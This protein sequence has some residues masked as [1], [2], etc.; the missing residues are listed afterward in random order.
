MGT[1]YYRVPSSEEVIRKQQKL[2]LRLQELD[3][4]NP[5]N[6]ADEFKVLQPNDEWPKISPWDEFVEDMSVHLG[7]RSSGWKFCWN[8]HDNKYYSNKEELLKFIRSGRIVDE[9]GKSEDIEEFIQMALNWGGADGTIVD[10]DYFEK[11]ER[12]SWAY[13]RQED[14]YDRIIDGLRVSSSTDFS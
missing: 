5:S 7:K 10:K 9:Y 3:W 1:N 4:W 12:M 11:N 13:L 8:F 2:N 6:A 14:Y